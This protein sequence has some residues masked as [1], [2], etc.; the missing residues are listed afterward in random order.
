MRIASASVNMA[1]SIVDIENFLDMYARL[2]ERVLYFT[3]DKL[4]DRPISFTKN[5]LD[6]DM[7]NEYPFAIKRLLKNAS[8][9]NKV[10]FLLYRGPYCTAGLI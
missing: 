9:F 3:V 10:C 1:S 5:E 4:I 8:E 7:A 2:R 6:F